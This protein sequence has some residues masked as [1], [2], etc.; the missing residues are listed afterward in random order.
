MSSGYNITKRSIEAIKSRIDIAEYIQTISNK[1]NLPKQDSPPTEGRNTNEGLKKRQDF[2][3]HKTGKSFPNIFNQNVFSDATQVNGNCE[4][5]IGTAQIPLGI[6]GQLNIIGTAAKGDFYVPLATSEGALVASYHRGAK[7]SRMCGG[8]TSICYLEGVQRSPVFR[9]DNMGEMSTFLI[10]AIENS[11]KFQDIIA[12]GS[13]HAKILDVK[14][15]I[16]GNQ[17]IINIEFYTADAAGQNMVTICTD[18]ICKWLV[19]NSPIKPTIWFIESNYSGDKKASA[20]SFMHVRGKKVSAEVNLTK[21][22]V[23]K[24]L[25]CKPEDMVQYW[26]TSTI[27]VIQSGSIGAQGHVAN[28]LTA[29]F[30]ATGQDVACI[31][32]ASVGITRME[33]TSNGGVYV[34]VTLP[35]LIVGTVGGGTGLPTQRECLEMIDCFGNGK[36]HKFAEIAAGLALAGEISIAAAIASGQFSQA[37][38]K[39]GR[40]KP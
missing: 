32:E 23:E 17:L 26:Q 28:G 29:L 9:F 31:S 19:E 38:Q 8:I 5:F 13:S 1:S 34:S 21:E 4:N 6:I 37:H 20:V 15:N 14:F 35:N 11:E 25:R 7:A 16:E 10:F 39:F 2:L 18:I 24:I 33:L 3:H 36:A 12:R 40:K 30:I 22:V 27:G